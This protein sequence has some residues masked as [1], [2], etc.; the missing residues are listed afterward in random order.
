MIPLS[1][2]AQPTRAST[3]R[4]RLSW[5]DLAIL[6]AISLWGS[7]YVVSKAATDTVPPLAWNALRFSAAAVGFYVLLRAAKVRLAIPRPLWW[8][9]ILSSL[10]GHALYQPLFI[11]GLHLT[12][13]SNAVLI[14]TIGPIWIIV[15]NAVRGQERITRAAVLG[16]FVALTGVVIVIIGRFAG[17]H[18]AGG[19]GITGDL[20]L[21]ACTIAW[22]AGVLLTR[23]PLQAGE[24]IVATFWMT[25][26]GAVTQMVIGTPALL[27]MEWR[28]ITPG[29]VTAMLYSGVMCVAVGSVLF[30]FGVAQIGTSRASVFMYVQPLVTALL[31]VLF[32]NEQFTPLL[33]GGGL[34]IFIGVNLARRT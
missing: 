3:F 33:I 22:A 18:E 24:P 31:A 34:L 1:Q 2:P 5:V 4:V 32:L 26:C 10:V 9:L 7:N 8:P 19:A 28:V 21:I 13:A 23:K 16:L 29:I 27:T 14:L 6:L 12:S 17:Q 20:L 25:V 15:F 11:N 30:N